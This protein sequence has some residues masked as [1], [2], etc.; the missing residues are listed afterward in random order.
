MKRASMISLSHSFTQAGSRA[1]WKEKACRGQS[2]VVLG[3][4]PLHVPPPR[5]RQSHVRGIAGAPIGRQS[6]VRGITEAAICR[7]SHV[8]GITEAAIGRQSHVRGITEAAICRQS[9]VRGITEAAIC[10]QLHVRGIT[11]AS[12]DR[13]FHK[14]AYDLLLP[15]NRTRLTDENPALRLRGNLG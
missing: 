13:I 12:R 3:F 5:G 2:G 14:T 6:H 7:Q 8:R 4:A 10:R 9:H 11:G 15:A 1:A